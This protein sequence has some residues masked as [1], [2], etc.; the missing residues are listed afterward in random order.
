MLENVLEA[1]SRAVVAEASASVTGVNAQIGARVGRVEVGISNTPLQA[2]AEG[3]GAIA[4]TGASL[5]YA[6]ASA[7]FHA[8]EARAGPFAARAGLKF[9]AGIRN[10]VPEVDLGPVTVPCCIM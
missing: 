1:N 10:G 6:G 9:G 8:G 5:E 3:P 2:H 7:G 4:E